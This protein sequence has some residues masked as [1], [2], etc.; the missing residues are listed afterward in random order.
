MLPTLALA[1]ALQLDA[2]QARLVQEADA[3]VM[4]FAWT[5][6]RASV[7]CGFELR[8]ADAT[9]DLRSARYL[10]NAEPPYAPVAASDELLIQLVTRFNATHGAYK[11]ELMRGVFVVRPSER[12]PIADE[13]LDRAYTG[14]P[15]DVDSAIRA[16]LQLFDATFKPVVGGLGGSFLGY[17]PDS[18]RRLWP[19]EV[20]GGPGVRVIDALNQIAL[21]IKESGWLVM[22]PANEDAV[23]YGFL[24]PSGWV[25]SGTARGLKNP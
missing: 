23:V 3:P 4:E 9:F 13:Y 16:E 14:G 15:I 18:V 25:N 10:R 19:I 21:Q 7:P 20:A 8:S 5:L 2:S 12:I 6:A 11:A 22:M 24:T 1:A 17:V